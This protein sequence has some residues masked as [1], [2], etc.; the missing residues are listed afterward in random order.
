LGVISG[1]RKLTDVQ[2]HPLTT[3]LVGV[4][5]ERML[6]AKCAIETFA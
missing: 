1:L 5:I 6:C 3:T 4:E 2:A